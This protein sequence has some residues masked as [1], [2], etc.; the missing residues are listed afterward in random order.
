MVDAVRVLSGDG[1]R[2]R[3]RWLHDAIYTI[4]KM[5]IQAYQKATDRDW[6][7]LSLLDTEALYLAMI[8]QASC[9]CILNIEGLMSVC[10]RPKLSPWG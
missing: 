8:S 5:S 6:R 1:G 4:R 7:S 9:Q 3:N 2:S 10:K